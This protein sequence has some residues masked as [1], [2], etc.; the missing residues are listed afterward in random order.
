MAKDQEKKEYKTGQMQ[1]NGLMYDPVYDFNKDGKVDWVEDSVRMEEQRRAQKLWEE[2]HGEQP[3]HNTPR[4]QVQA[5]GASAGGCLGSLLTVFFSLGGIGLCFTTESILLKILFIFGGLALALASAHF[6]G[7]FGTKQKDDKELGAA[8][9]AAVKAKQRIEYAVQTDKAKLIKRIAIVSAVL[10]AVVL[11]C[12]I[13]NINAHYYRQAISL[14]NSGEYASARQSLSKIEESKYKEKAELHDFCYALENYKSGKRVY[15]PDYTYNAYSFDFKFSDD[16]EAKKRAINKQ[17]EKQKKEYEQKSYDNLYDSIWNKP[18]EKET[19]TK[20]TTKQ[21]TTKKPTTKRSGGTAVKG[22]G[23]IGGRGYSGNVPYNKGGSSGSKKKTTTTK[24]AA[25]KAYD[26]YHAADY[27]HP[28]DFY[29][30]YYD[31]FYD[32]EDAEDYWYEHQ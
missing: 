5:S 23:S 9:T 2:E 13:G 31:D 1:D 7:L 30:D 4:P 32:Y 14:I 21:T 20:P 19:T 12:N 25:T 11:L 17:L 8:E 10:I 16:I 29:Y 22:S 18:S 28:D 24:K 15:G 26:P 27:V 3:Q 6:C